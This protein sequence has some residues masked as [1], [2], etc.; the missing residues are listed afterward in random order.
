MMCEVVIDAPIKGNLE[1]VQSLFSR[2]LTE[3]RNAT[4]M[5]RYRLAVLAGM[6]QQAMFAVETG[7][8]PPSEANLKALAA[9]AELGIP[10]ERL[11]AWADLD[12]LGQEGMANMIKAGLF[13][14]GDDLADAVLEAV[15]RL[16]GELPTTGQ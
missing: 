10:Y 14:P 4:G 16:S 8:R 2:N 12:R 6:S 5:S 15:N 11:R 1:A 7:T 9:V 3:A 13:K